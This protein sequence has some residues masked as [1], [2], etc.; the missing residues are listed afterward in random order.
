[1]SFDIAIFLAATGITT[2]EIVEA[3]AVGL[4]LSA[5]SGKNSAF[6]YVA[7]GILAV[8]IPTLIL[9]KL[10]ALLPDVYVRTVGGALL[11]YFG[12]RLIKSARRS[13]LKSRS[14][15]GFGTGLEEESHRGLMYTAFSVGAIEAFEAAI[16]LV[17]LLPVDFSSTIFGIIV[18]TVIV[19]VSTYIL[20]KQVRKVKQANMKILVSALLLSFSAFWFGEIF[21]VLSDLLL[22]PLFTMFFIIV[23]VVA[24]RRSPPPTKTKQD[25]TR[26]ID[27]NEESA[28]K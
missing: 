13:V 25:L 2:L 15:G 20:R 4:A 3:A 22:I 28:T 27:R 1:M 10:I 11:L 6:L 23:Y 16:V 14:P 5:H 7:F 8:I 24:N 21:F 12:L 9:G 19:V 18:G 17:G 26:P